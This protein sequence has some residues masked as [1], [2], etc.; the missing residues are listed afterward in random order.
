MPILNKVVIPDDPAK[1]EN[2][3]GVTE[4]PA[5]SSIFLEFTLDL[6]LL[7]YAYG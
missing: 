2:L 4:N 5:V 6:L 3:L 7:P 1:R